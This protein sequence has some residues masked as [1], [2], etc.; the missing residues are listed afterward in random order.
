M[1]SVYAYH[2]EVEN[3]W[4]V[5]QRDRRRQRELALVVLVA[6]PVVAALIGYTWLHV[7]MLHSAYRL[8]ELAGELAEAERLRGALAVEAAAFA[9]LGEVERRAAAE[10]GMTE[11]TVETTWTYDEVMAQPPAPPAEDREPLP[12]PPGRPEAMP[13]VSPS[14]PASALPPDTVPD[15][16]H[17]ADGPASP[18]TTAGPQAPAASVEEATP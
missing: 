18:G 14:P 2:R 12:L 1:P 7:R 11:Q 10:L 15:G 3:A 8:Q 17:G 13:P 9:A 5:R 6:L 4:L 16:Q